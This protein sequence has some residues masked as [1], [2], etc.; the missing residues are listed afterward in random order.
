MQIKTEA[1]SV[2]RILVVDEEE[3]VR[4]MLIDTLSKDDVIVD[5]AEDTEEAIRL[6]NISRPDVIVTDADLDGSNGID[7]LDHFRDIPAVVIGDSRGTD[8]LDLSRYAPVEYMKKP[9][10]LNLLKRA[11]RIETAFKGREDIEIVKQNEI[12]RTSCHEMAEQFRGV[13]KQ[14]HNS[15]L[16][17]Q[18]Q[19]SLI[20][21]KT[22]DAIFS[23]FFHTYV[24]NC[25]SISGI[26]LV[27]DSRANLKVCGRFGVPMPD[28]LGYCRKLSGPVCE[29]VFDDPDVQIIHPEERADL[30]SADLRKFLPGISVLAIPLM[31][32][33][34]ELIGMVLMYRKGEQPFEDKEIE[35][36]RNLA[37]PTAMAIQAVE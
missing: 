11:I 28:S 19:Q 4:A 2:T 33:A 6:A 12:L 23:S 7:L 26:S 20:S 18:Y 35:L 5:A 17:I 37:Y 30:Y 8:D 15:R 3:M 36:S 1:E 13:S 34:G 10:D 27:C 21:A 22:D 29:M 14:L 32:S 24:R 31:I 25:G 9:L 16:V